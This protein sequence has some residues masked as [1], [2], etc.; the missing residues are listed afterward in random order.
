MRRIKFI[1]IL[2]GISLLLFIFLVSCRN[3]DTDNKIL[4]SGPVA[5][6]VNLA[7]DDFEDVTNKNI[8]ASANGVFGSSQNLTQRREVSFGGGFDLIAELKPDAVSLKNTQ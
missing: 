5:I 4:D 2:L 6:N 8:Q 3:S 1:D 7:H